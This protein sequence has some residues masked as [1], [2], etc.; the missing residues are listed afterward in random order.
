MVPSLFGGKVG[1]GIAVGAEGGSS[2]PDVIQV[3][4]SKN[5]MEAGGAVEVE[6]LRIQGF[7]RSNDAWVGGLVL[8]KSND[9]KFFAAD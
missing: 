4:L 2:E 6:S 8:E 5:L 1:A 7:A 9:F 3:F